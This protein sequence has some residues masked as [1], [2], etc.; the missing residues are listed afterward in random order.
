MPLTTVARGRVYDW[1]HAIGRGAA[2]GTGFNYVQSMCLAKDGVCYTSNRG[3]EN[4]FGMRVNK[5]KIGGP[6]GE[7]LLAEFFQYGQDNG[8]SIWPFGVAAGDKGNVYCS[9]EWTNTISVFDADGKFIRKW[10]STGSGD[11]ELMRPGGI[12]IEANGNV[13]V[14]DSGNC[15]LQV[16]TP[17]GKFVGKCGG[18][19]K[20][21]GEFNQP[22]GIT[23][24]KAGRIYVADWKNHRIQIL[25]PEG[26][27]LTAI[28]RHGTITPP[29]GAYAVTIFGP[30]ISAAGEMAGYPKPDLFNHPTDVAVDPDG[31]IYVCDWGNHR[32]CTFDAEG[33]PIAHLIG[34][35]QVMSKWGQQS[36][37]AN[38]DMM[39][40][41]RRVRSLEPQYRFCFP[42]A[43]DFDPDTDNIVVAD[44]QR[45]RLQVYKKVRNYTDFQAN[46]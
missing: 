17:E 27:F 12:A 8:K 46:L 16:F 20:G 23:T 43:V 13:I 30:Y 35:A 34:D 45:N 11:G 40:A 5:I 18:P 38:P 14:V 28:G 31:D 22:W 21:E 26:K 19:G 6:G 42:T 37:D 36:I 24:D 33:G 44:S 29:E 7:E 4:N 9:D 1:S 25:S 2:T 39:K 32:I 10:G 3:N 41:R 15:R